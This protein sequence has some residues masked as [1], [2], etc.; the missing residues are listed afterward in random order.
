[1]PINELD[2]LLTYKCNLECDHC[3]VFGSPNARGVMKIADIRKILKEAKKIKT[4]DWI[5]IEGGEP[6]LYYQILLWGLREA[7]NQGFKTGFI[8]NAYWAT[9]IEDAKEWL[10]PISEIGISKMIV[11]DDLFTTGRKKKTFRNMLFTQPRRWGFL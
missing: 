8:T 9:S 1:M 6:V 7:K 10:K 2:L 11:S 3:F 5:Y 4:I